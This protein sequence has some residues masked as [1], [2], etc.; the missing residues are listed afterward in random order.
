MD[1]D[2]DDRIA[3]R[4]TLGDYINT[5]TFLGQLLTFTDVDLEKLFVFAKHLRRLLPSQ[6]QALPVD[7]QEK[8]DLESLNMRLTFTGPVSL[9]R[10]TGDV[11]PVTKPGP[12]QKPAE[13]LEP[14]SAI[15]AELNERLGA[16]LTD[17]DKVTI[18][19]PPGPP[20]RRRN[21]EGERPRQPVRDGAP[22]VW[23]D[24][25]GP[26]ARH[27]GDELQALQARGRR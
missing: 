24:R 5:Y 27:R 16:D 25:P 20:C 11:D 23:P 8:I 9:T 19:P 22:R 26:P 4:K 21:P 7:V 13:R 17:E 3:S 1:L 14:L 12:G 6:E 10:G 15:I 18:G 2:E